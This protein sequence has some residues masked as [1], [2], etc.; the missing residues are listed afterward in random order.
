MDTLAAG[1]RLVV[2]LRR[3]ESSESAPFDSP[4][5]GPLSDLDRVQ[6]N[7]RHAELHLGFLAYETSGT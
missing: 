2:A 5:V 1:A 7:L 6:L 4:A 3:L